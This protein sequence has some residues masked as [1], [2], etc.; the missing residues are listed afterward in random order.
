VTAALI[1]GNLAYAVTAAAPVVRDILWLRILGGVA[2]VGFIVVILMSP[3]GPT[4]VFLAWSLLFLAINLFQIGQLILERR[5]I[6]LGEEDQDLHAAVFPN[7]PVGEFRILLKA[8]RRHDLP[9][10]TVIIEQGDAVAEVLLIERGA[11]RL[12]RDGRLLDRLVAGHMLGEIAF[13]AQRPFSSR[14]VVDIPT[15]VVAWEPS[16]LNRLFLRRPSLALGFH[17]AFIGQL[18]RVTTDAR[19]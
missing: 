19:G 16:I 12:E 4:Y 6:R 8:G 7:L 18:R 2:N 3:G 5:N 14:A 10:D 1:I 15:R 17:A 13:V 11:V 9:P